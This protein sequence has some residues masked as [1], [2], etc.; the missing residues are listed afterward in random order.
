G[1]GIYA[2]LYEA[3]KKTYQVDKRFIPNQENCEKYDRLFSINR[4]LYPVLKEINRDLTYFKE[5]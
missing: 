3:T 5:D 4:K 2:D 1:T